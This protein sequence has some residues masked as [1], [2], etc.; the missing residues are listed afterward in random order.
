[1]PDIQITDAM[2]KPVGIKID[3]KH[4]SSLLKYLKS[5][6][7]HLAVVPDFLKR[8]D[9]PLSQA[10]TT[11]I[12][13]QASVKHGFQ[14]GNIQPEIDITPSAQATIGVNVS[15]GTDV[16][17]GDA[18]SIPATVPDHGA[19]VS[20]G[21]QGSL[22]LG[23]SGSDGD[24]SFGLDET[25]TV[26]MQ[27]FKAFSL[28]LVEPTLGDA[29][30]RTFSSYVLPAD[31][32]D[33]QQ[34]GP[35]DIATISGQGKLKV[36]GAVTAKAYP[37]PLASVDLPLSMGSIDLNAGATAKL[38]ASFTM[39]GEYQVRARR[40]DADMIELS[41]LRQHGTKF[42]ADLSAMGG[43]S[44]KLGDTDLASVVFGAMSKDP[45]HDKAMLADLRPGERGTLSDAIKNGLDHS[46]HASLDLMLSA[47]ADDQT[48]FQYHI[49]L[50]KLD[51]SGS[52]AIHK[53]LDGD[54]RLLT[55][56]EGAAQDAGVLAPG[57]TM[58][59]SLLSRVCKQGL[60]LH[61][62]LIG[63]LNFVSVSELIRK[64]EVLT[65]SVT[66]DVTIK[67]TVT[68]NSIAAIVEPLKRDEALRKVLF[69]SV[70]ATTCY[71]AGKAISPLTLS[72]AQVHFALNQNTN[73]QIM[74][75]YLSWFVALHLLAQPAAD[76]YLAHFNDGGPSTCVLRTFFANA[77]C[78]ALFF[79]AAGQLRPKTYFLEVGRQAMR[80][81]L[82]PGLQPIDALRS[83]ILDDAIWPT[84]IATGANVN[85]GP[86]VGI[87]TED[88]R[89]SILI[90]DVY[91][92]SE[93]ARTMTQSASS[94]QEM[95]ALVGN[96]DPATLMG[97]NQFK[98]KRDQL[99]KNLASM[100][101]ASKARFDE[102]WGMIS[103]FWAS[104]FSSGAYGKTATQA[105]TLELGSPTMQLKP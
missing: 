26:S 56:M 27:F 51:A 9:L 76:S 22:D 93:W 46:L 99:Q 52:M 50:A 58:L 82:D 23:L 13:F 33:L 45:M 80:A 68:A 28:T 2:D 30:G 5:E 77:D 86:L 16:F 12:Q 25:T 8:K 105:F 84:A 61:L 69:D 10:A 17:S 40:V 48:L 6:L 75:D 83:Q 66:G 104:G 42:V 65:D 74:S 63:L 3:L 4:P 31:I 57:V 36:S 18:F 7:L 88:R 85:L 78:E 103:L 19:Y 94:V 55:A 20:L 44:T 90:G 60:T 29:V 53:A 41:F 81:L 73:H 62:N 35:G 102:P 38:S 67:E 79:D 97:N 59:N 24:L 1:M 11:P 34:L 14:L 37:N 92:I 15:P 100:A 95:R 49:Q 21:L 98:S 54:L 71:R 89:V 64:S 32:S 91:V 96:A 72:C 70:L 101:K 43:V 87:G 39:S 47:E